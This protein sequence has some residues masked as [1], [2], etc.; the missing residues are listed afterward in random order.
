[1]GSRARAKLQ[2]HI[3][4]WKARGKLEPGLSHSCL[5]ISQGS[6]SHSIGMFPNLFDQPTP[7]SHSP[8]ISA[9]SHP[10]FSLSTTGSWQPPSLASPA[11]S[12][13]PQLPT[14]SEAR[15]LPTQ[16][17]RFL[18]PHA[19]SSSRQG[20]SSLSLPP[21]PHVCWSKPLLLTCGPGASSIG[22]SWRCIRNESSQACPH[23]LN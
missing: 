6:S 19:A 14:S 5:F 17:Q 20:E 2:C 22:T 11:S 16:G 12:Q 7:A 10:A 9:L 4:D 3:C 15:K 8:F 21:A 1:M 18:V 23:L 13:L